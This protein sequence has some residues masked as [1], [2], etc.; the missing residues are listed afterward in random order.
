[1]LPRL[2]DH[3][4]WADDRVADSLA[5]LSVPDPALLKI[6]SHVLGAEAIWIARI[7]GI[8]SEIAVF[9]EFD[10][11]T[12]REVAARNH[13]SLKAIPLTE[14][15]RARTLT[16]TNQ[17]GETYTNSVDEILHHVCM[18]GMHHRGQVIRGVRQGGGTPIGTDFITF[19]REH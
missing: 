12:C 1:M 17:R 16:Y 13:V 2:I 5:T 9:P 8:P 11:P 19:V 15:G 14:A 10:L 3:L 4:I 7:T 18:H 6:Y